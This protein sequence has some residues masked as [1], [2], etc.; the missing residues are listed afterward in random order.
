MENRL[1]GPELPGWFI[2]TSEDFLAG[3]LG[4]GGIGSASE[5]GTLSY[6]EGNLPNGSGDNGITFTEEFIDR[7]EFRGGYRLSSAS[8]RALVSSEMTLDELFFPA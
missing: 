7:G 2:P 5:V 8:F 6:S 1:D 3:K 4:T